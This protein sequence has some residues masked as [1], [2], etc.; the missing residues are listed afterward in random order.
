MKKLLF[1]ALLLASCLSPAF[2]AVYFVAVDG[3]DHN[4]GSQLQP[5]ATVQRAQSAARPGDTVYLRGG[6]YHLTES[7]ISERVRGYACV[8]Y[9]DKSGREG[10]YICYF[11]YP[12]ETPVFDYSAV[13]PADYRVAAFYVTG[14]WLHLRGFDVT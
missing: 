3:N 6:V 10:R 1:S 12:G 4:P 8:S 2:A 7:Q 9:L 5:F 14:S 11:G 13:K